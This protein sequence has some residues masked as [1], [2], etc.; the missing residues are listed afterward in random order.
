M[1]MMGNAAMFSNRIM[2]FKRVDLAELL[3][4]RV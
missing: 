3:T 4:Q 2:G 1:L